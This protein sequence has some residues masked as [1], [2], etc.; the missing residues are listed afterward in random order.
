[1]II[2]SDIIK[3][4]NQLGVQTKHSERV[5]HRTCVK[6]WFLLHFYGF[7]LPICFAAKSRN[8]RKNSCSLLKVKVGYNSKSPAQSH[9]VA[10]ETK[11]IENLIF[12]EIF[13]ATRLLHN[14]WSLS[15]ERA[16]SKNVI[17][18]LSFRAMAERDNC[19]IKGS[20]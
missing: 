18:D 16:G 17:K 1:M 19:A 13:I 2:I 6:F 3:G 8:Y 9:I 20:N 15:S 11:K 7:F 4:L 5:V 12:H 10:R 14:C